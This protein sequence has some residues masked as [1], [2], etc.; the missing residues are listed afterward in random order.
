MADYLTLI[1]AE[2][3]ARAG[4][5]MRDAATSMQSA[6]SSLAGSLEQNQRFMDDWLSRLDCMLQDRNSYLGQTLAG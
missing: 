2:D 6:A 1:G 4:Y 3:V 5:T